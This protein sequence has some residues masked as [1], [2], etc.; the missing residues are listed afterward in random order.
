MNFQ[1]RV[2]ALSLPKAPDGWR[3]KYIIHSGETPWWEI[4]ILEERQRAWRRQRR[5]KSRKDHPELHAEEMR[6]YYEGH[7]GLH[8]RQ[9]RD[10]YKNHPGYHAEEMRNF[11]G[12]HLG[13]HAE[14][15]REYT[16]TPKGRAYAA[17]GTARRRER[18]TD[19]ALYAARVLI[20]HD[21]QESCAECSIPYDISH[22][23][24]HILALCNGGTDDW[25]NLQPLCI[26]CHRKK[27]ARDVMEFRK[28]PAVKIE[29][30][31]NFFDNLRQKLHSEER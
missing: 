24:D 25:D 18:S 31:V 12:N 27:T 16:K 4:N 21:L 13:Y 1:E 23:I 7:P 10:F 5:R 30:S 17:N 8:A 22:Q 11:Y 26:L 28:Q 19:P 20:L 2:A 3:E 29:Q 14:E 9:M 6:K 15:M